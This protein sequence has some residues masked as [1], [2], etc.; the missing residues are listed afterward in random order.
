VATDANVGIRESAPLSALHVNGSQS[1]KR[2]TSGAG[3]YAVVNTDFIVAKTGITGGGDTVTLPVA[4][5]AGVGKVFHVK[6]ESGTAAANNITV[7]GNG[8]ETING[9]ASTVISTN[10][11]SVSVYCDGANWF[12]F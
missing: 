1:V 4:A 2:T 6:D 10:Y 11:G 7:D 8:A 3:A 5:L 12:T 9:A